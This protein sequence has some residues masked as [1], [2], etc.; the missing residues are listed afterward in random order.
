MKH[1]E[2]QIIAMNQEINEF[3]NEGVAIARHPDT[4]KIIAIIPQSYV[5]R[6]QAVGEALIPGSVS[7][8]LNGK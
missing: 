5:F 6:M 3:L 1:T 8:R 4:H 2:E 7:R